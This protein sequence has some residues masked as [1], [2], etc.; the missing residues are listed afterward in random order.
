M[1]YITQKYERKKKISKQR[2]K[3]SGSSIMNIHYEKMDHFVNLQDVVLKEKQLELTNLQE[4]VKNNNIEYY[5]NKINILN[6]E[7]Q[8]I[9]ECKEENAYYMDVLY[10]ISQYIEIEEDDTKLEEKKEIMKQ[11]YY[12][13][14]LHLPN[15]ITD[16]ENCSLN[17]CSIC[18]TQNTVFEF[19][20]CFSCIECGSVTN[21]LV[22]PETLSFKDKQDT[23]FD[24]K[25]DYKKINYFIEWLNQIQG[26]EQSNI[27]Q[28]VIDSI[29]IELQ[30]EKITDVSNLDIDTVRILLKNYEHIP[31]I[32][33]KINCLTKLNIPEEIFEKLVFMFSEF[34]GPYEQYKPSNRKSI[35]AIKYI[36][37]KF[38][39][40]LDI[41]D[42]DSYFPLLKCREKTYKHEKIFKQ[43]VTHLAQNQTGKER[44]RI[45]WRF[46]PSV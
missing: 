31:N 22:L 5:I 18:N 3:K 32:I 27:P 16:K 6:Q 39:H 13:L 4:K 36:I 14:N 41:H 7:I 20:D 43:V 35:S 8:D 15:N 29:I 23:D 38:L 30:K 26:K 12:K 46:I 34:H 28:Y 19:E 24:N 25:V 42:Y 37:R 2:I 44:Y 11:Y 1:N 21:T 45:N 40:I 9:L 17:N 10:L 33:H